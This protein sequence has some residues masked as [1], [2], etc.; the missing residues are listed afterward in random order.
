MEGLKERT[1]LKVITYTLLPS[2]LFHHLYI[3]N[4]SE[5]S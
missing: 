1:N 3:A 2:Y 4:V 5:N